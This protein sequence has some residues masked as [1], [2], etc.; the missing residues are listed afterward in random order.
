[1]YVQHYGAAWPAI[2]PLL[3]DLYKTRFVNLPFIPVDWFDKVEAEHG[4]GDVILLPMASK[5][6]LGGTVANIP[7]WLNTQARID[8]WQTMYETVN[9]A[10]NN[11]ASNK[12]AQ[13]EL[14][15]WT[16]QANATFW[17]DLYEGTK[18][19]ADAIAPY[20]PLKSGSAMQNALIY[21][22][23][24]VGALALIMMFRK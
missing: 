1:M 18:A 14:E 8:A 3:L 5:N 16:A 23:V 15:V 11:F 20:N 10:I 24:A 7:D 4:Q 19:V 6:W 12:L 22:G 2:V 9:H 17:N 21:G 13:G